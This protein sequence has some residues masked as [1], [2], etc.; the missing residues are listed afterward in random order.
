MTNARINN[1]RSIIIVYLY[2][3]RVGEYLPLRAAHGVRGEHPGPFSLALAK[4]RYSYSI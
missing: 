1:D 4:F 3:N 2:L